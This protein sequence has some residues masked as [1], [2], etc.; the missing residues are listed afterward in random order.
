MKK[1]LVTGTAGFI[2][3]HLAKRLLDEGWSVTGIDNI[4]DYYDRGIKYARLALTGIDGRSVGFGK[5]VRSSL[6]PDYS[7][8]RMNLEDKKAMTKLFDQEGFEYV[9][10]LAAQ[11]GVRYSLENPHAYIDSNM[12]GFLNILEGC[13]RN[14]AKHLVYASSSSVYGL[15]SRLPLSTHHGVDHPVSLYAATKR[16]NELMAHTYSHLYGIATTGLRFFTVYGPWGRPDMAIFLFT[17]AILEGKP[18][19]IFNH[20]DMLRDFTYVDDIVEGVLK[21]L[22]HK[23]KPSSGTDTEHPDPATSTAPFRLYNI[24]NSEPVKLLDFVDAIEKQLGKKAL[25]KLLPMQPGDVQRTFSDITD[26]R[27]DFGYEPK[28][29]VEQGI[30]RFIDWYLDYYGIK[31]GNK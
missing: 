6:Y 3:F 28:T 23:A 20:G 10:H 11:A 27:D 22:P 31:T 30:A 2:G 8:I 5:A 29:G 26:L 17:K 24:G 13:R 16:A 4:N 12:T 7:F 19:E 14:G 9:C 15:N 18:V 21:V 1:I 25:R